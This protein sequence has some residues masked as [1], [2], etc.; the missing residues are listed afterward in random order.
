MI[1]LDRSRLELI[2]FGAG[3]GV[4]IKDLGGEVAVA[5]LPRMGRRAARRNQVKSD[6]VKVWAV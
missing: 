3:S 1:G 5:T 4:L 2:R 6:Q